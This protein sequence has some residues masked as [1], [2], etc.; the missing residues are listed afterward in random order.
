[1]ATTGDG[2]RSSHLSSYNLYEQRQ[3][4]GTDPNLPE[5]PEEPEADDPVDLENTTSI[6]TRT[7]SMNSFH[8]Q[9]HTNRSNYEE[10]RGANLLQQMTSDEL[11]H[12]R[13]ESGNVF[14][15]FYGKKEWQLVEWFGKSQL[16]QAQINS[17]LQLD[18]VSII[19]F[20][21]RLRS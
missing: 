5:Q 1:M 21:L 12:F 18:I 17:F 9:F 15:P 11:H 16:S 10:G 19:T 4:G 20:L 6:D 2:P 3:D 8:Q 7:A 13:E 14:F